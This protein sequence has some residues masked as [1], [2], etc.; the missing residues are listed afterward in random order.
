MMIKYILIITIIAALMPTAIPNGLVSATTERGLFSA[1]SFE[2]GDPGTLR[3]TEV[4]SGGETK[5]MALKAEN[6]D[7]DSKP[8]S[9]FEITADNVLSIDLNDEV[10]IHTDDNVDFTK[11]LVTD[12]TEKKKSIDISD[13]GEISFNGYKQGVYVLNVVIND[14]FAFEA[15]IVIGPETQQIINREITRV[16]TKQITDIDI[17][18]IFEVDCGKDFHVD[19][20]GLCVPDKPDPITPPVTPPITPEPQK[21]YCDVPNPSNPCHDRQDGDDINGYPCL[22]GSLKEDWRDCNGDTEAELTAEPEPTPIPESDP[23]P[24]PTPSVDPSLLA[25]SQPQCEFGVNLETGLCDTED[26]LS[27][28]S[29]Q[30]PLI[31]TPEP[32]ITPDGLFS[33]EE[34][35]EEEIVEEEPE[36]EIVEEEPEEEPEDE[37]EGNGETNDDN[38]FGQ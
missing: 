9:D 13:S 4:G 3:I 30:E 5:E 25:R 20:D 26:I 31:P 11:A 36:E 37:P 28:P 1:I 21:T 16:N 2:S 24:T 8:V 29:T 38:T 14:E 32:T 27:E 10:R 33:T 19:E 22:D 7:G 18:I 12:S 35:P 17:R 6:E 34:E 15:I 23:E